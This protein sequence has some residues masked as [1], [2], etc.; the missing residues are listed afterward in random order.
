MTSE[1]SFEN[2]IKKHLKE[3]GCWFVKYWGGAVYTKSGIPDLLCCIGS[4]FV[5]IEVKGE[6]GKPS[7]LQLYNIR[8][9][10]QAGGYAVVLY[11]KQ[12][13]KFKK[14]CEL[15]KSNDVDNA[16]NLVEEI[17]ERWWWKLNVLSL[18]DGISCGQVALEKA[19]I[20]VNKYFASEIEE[21]AIK[22]TQFNYPNTIQLG[23]VERIK[24][25]NGILYTENGEYRVDIDLVI[26]GSPCQSFSVACKTDKRTGLNGV[27]GLVD[28]FIRVLKEVRPKYYLLENVASMKKADK[29]YITSKLGGGQPLKINSQDFSAQL[30]NRYYW[31]NIPF[32]GYEPKQIF[33]QDVLT[34]GYTDRKKARAVT[35]VDS[36]PIKKKI[37]MFHRFYKTGFTTLIF[38]DEQHY[39]DCVEHYNKY[40]NCSA[41][42]IQERLRQNDID[43]SVYDGI[44]YP[45]VNEYER[46]Q[47]LPINYTNCLPF[48]N[49]V[50]AIGNGWTVEVIKH[51]FTGMKGGEQDMQFSHSRVELFKRNPLLYKLRYIGKLKTLPPDDANNPLIVGTALHTGLEKGV[52]VSVKEY[53]DSYPIATDRH[54]EEV[55][56]L[57]KVIPMTRE[58]IPPGGEYEVKIET[59]DYIGFIDY[60]APVTGFYDSVVPDAYDIYD[61]KYSNSIKHYKESRQL[62]LYKYFFEKCNP[63]KQIRNL[64]FLF[65]P[66][67]SIRQ[68]KTETLEE[69]RRRIFEEL[70]NVSPTL[71]QIEY[72]PNQV[73]DY[74]LDVKSILEAEEYPLNV[75]DPFYRYSEFK[76]YIE[77]GVDYMI[78]PKNERRNIEEINKKVVWLYGSPFSGKTT[79]AN[80]FPDPLILNTDGNIKFVDAPYISIKNKVEVNGRRTITTLAWE[81]FKETI[82]ELEKKDNDFKT[83]IVDLLEDCYEHC[84]LYMYEQMGITHESDDSFKAWDKV[85]TEYLSTMKRLVNLDYENIILISHEDTSKDIMKKSGDKITAIKP[86]IQDKVA[87]KIAGMVDIVAR[88]VADGDDRVLSFKTNEVIFGGGR[89]KTSYSEI[90]LDYD[91]FLK[92]YEEANENAVASLSGKK[93][94]EPKKR[95]NKKK[96]KVEKVEV[97]EQ[98]K[99]P[100]DNEDV[101]DEAIDTEFTEVEEDAEDKPEEPKEEK[102]KRKRRTR[103]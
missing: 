56:K 63:G 34:T 70:E 15:L 99:L 72:D 95:S 75:K 9:I 28:E 44:R 90:D 101:D 13:D 93:K 24:Y 20:K 21:S 80:K 51:I 46:L 19:G 23:N 77:K 42:E 18:F 31:T 6:K 5:A 32:T 96:E 102:P 66:K 7:E 58:L 84:R 30:R 98:D 11:P 55:I 2:R 69:F 103:E 8:K 14:L 82:A 65:A 64:Y 45:T 87:T 86:N 52:E 37:S 68:K 88:V 92:V 78:L 43:L 29:D 48:K 26:G 76:D 89:L 100:F 73:I 12:F 17:N 53:Y 33:L 60:L 74:L 41:K 91:E 40:F 36:R 67:V 16:R 47:T 83:I 85:R 81:I 59:D 39:K 22:I 97:V 79:F 25:K 61:F 49:R 54:I 4:Y 35:T 94:E 27:S 50:H 62:H 71:L 10:N 1:K 3:Q 57:E 38:K